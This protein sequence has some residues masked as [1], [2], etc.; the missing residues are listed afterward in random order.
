MYAITIPLSWK[1]NDYTGHLT[2][3]I[4][5]HS[6]CNC[7][8][9]PMAHTAVSMYRLLMTSKQLCTSSH[10]AHVW[11][12]TH[13][14]SHHIHTIWHEWS[15]FM[16]SHTRNS[17]YQIFSLGH[18][19]HSLGHH[20]T[21]CMSSSPTVSV[22]TST[23]SVISHPTYPWHHSNYMEGITGSVSVITYPLCFWQNIH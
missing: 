3:H 16:S 21:L 9:T 1:H 11:H 8:I 2:R 23:A 13:S 4:W 19:I 7:V 10:L 14:T 20:T 12:H 6:H 18:H 17:W 15:C 22:L 5:H